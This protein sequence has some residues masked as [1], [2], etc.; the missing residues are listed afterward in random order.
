MST[1]DD[2]PS[3]DDEEGIQLIENDDELQFDEEIEEKN[4][5]IPSA[6]SSARKPI[7]FDEIDDKEIEKQRTKKRNRFD[8][9]RYKKTGKALVFD[10]GFSMF[11]SNK[12]AKS[13]FRFLS[14]SQTLS[15]RRAESS[16]R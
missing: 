5:E 1:I 10:V 11:F 7:V 9:E 4:E 13:V 6:R 14:E 3:Y 8:P 15:S 2:L 16:S 12:K